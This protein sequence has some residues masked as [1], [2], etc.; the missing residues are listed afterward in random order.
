[1]ITKQEYQT[2][3][4]KVKIYQKI[5]DDY[6]MQEKKEYEKKQQERESVCENSAEGHHY[7][8]TNSK[9]QSVSQMRCDY[10]G[11]IIN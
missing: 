5:V 4:E 10:C 8:S 9:W 2:A 6:W 3:T 1:M 11:K 7:T